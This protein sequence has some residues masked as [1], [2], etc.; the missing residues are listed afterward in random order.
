MFRISGAVLMFY[1]WI[2]SSAILLEAAGVSRAIGVNIDSVATAHSRL[3]SGLNRIGGVTGGGTLESIAAIVL[4]VTDVIMS[5][6]PLLTAGPEM[7]TGLG[8]PTPIVSIL[9]LPLAFIGF[10]LFIYV[11]GDRSL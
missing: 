3:D 8:A 4:G 7:L 5:V 1:I 11:I 10:R 9:Y 2:T 6:I